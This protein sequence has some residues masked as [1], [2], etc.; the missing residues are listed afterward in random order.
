MYIRAKI[1]KNKKTK[2]EYVKHQLVESYRTEK[3]PRQRILM[4]LGSLSLS[5]LQLRKLAVILEARLAG[6]TSLFEEETDLSHTAD[7][8]M[9]NYQF[10][11]SEGEAKNIREE[12]RELVNVDV[13]S[14]A[15]AESRSLGPEL[16]AHTYWE[17]L[18]FDTLL[19]SCGLTLSQQAL[20]KAVIIA[21]LIA[22]ASDLATW[23]WLRN[24]TALLELLPVN[25]S[26]IG[27]D[28]IYEIGDEL[29]IH[30]TKLEAALRKR[31][32]ILFPSET[33][34]FLYDLTNTYF[35]GSCVD[36]TLAKRG[37]SK[38]KRSD[39]P[40]VTLALVVDANG[41]PLHSQIYGGNQS[42]PET[43][44]GILERLYE[45]DE[46]DLF[47]QIRPTLVM[48]RG[49]AT[50]DNIQLLKDKTYPYIVVERRAVEKD[51]VKEFTE[52]KASFQRIDQKT[53]PHLSGN[54][55]TSEAVFVKKIP[56]E[57]G[58]RVLCVS[59]S[60]EKKEIAMDSLKEERFLQDLT[61]LQTTVAKGNVKLLEKVGERMGRLKERYPSIARH[62]E[63]ALDLDADQKKVVA[64]SWTKKPTRTERKTLTGCYV[65]ET[66]H[67]ELSA[68]EVWRL[69]T[70]LT[71]V[72]YAFRSLKTDLGVRPVYH[73]L[74]E[75]TRGHLF[76]SVLAYH[77]LICIEHQLRESGDH[78]K[79]ST[80]RKQLSTHQRSTVMLTDEHDQIHHIR[81]SGRPE[82]IH[83]EIYRFLDVKD[84]LKKKRQQITSK[85]VV[86]ELK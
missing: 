80:L 11:R 78:R 64:L 7:E 21:R 68:E 59:E 51:Y 63:I 23:S 19:N 72:E 1:T 34:L 12:E 81:V 79:W 82:S 27:K 71:Q 2:K 32:T 35:E 83:Q 36:N 47:K 38:E 70:T 57:D 9:G 17:R 40:L 56:W 8:V 60:R 45:Q 66:S 10:L 5:K 58:C 16:V 3:G 76:I 86:P 6:Q 62:Y 14:L 49:I 42:E 50:K 20:A 37:K 44:S 41:F 85:V 43:L 25:L 73:Q 84:P 13:N 33:T 52:A 24:Q 69:Y 29:L 53:G 77:L 28:A 75:R 74:A 65:I 55:T 26:E 30:K 46:P 15:T 22:P 39:C 54:V 61:A 31:E 4:E 67:K 18:G 48:D